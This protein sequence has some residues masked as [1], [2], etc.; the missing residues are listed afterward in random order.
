MSII[1]RYA[2]G[3]NVSG[4]ISTLYP[5]DPANKLPMF[6]IPKPIM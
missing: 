1:N 4:I 6:P 3:T 2:N 5:F